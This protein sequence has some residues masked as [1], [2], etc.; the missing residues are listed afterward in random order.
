MKI[1]VAFMVLI[2]VAAASAQ[3]VYENLKVN[4]V[5]QQAVKV[6]KPPIPPKKI[7]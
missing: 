3:T 5:T 6:V 2:S 7:K 4:G 1:V